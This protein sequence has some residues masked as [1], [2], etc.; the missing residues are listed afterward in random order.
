M[1]HPTH[2]KEFFIAL[3]VLALV[4]SLVSFAAYRFLTKTTVES[5]TDH[6]P[7]QTTTPDQQSRGETTIT[8]MHT[9]VVS[10]VV[11][12]P[13]VLYMWFGYAGLAAAVLCSLYFRI[14]HSQ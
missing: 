10:R 7:V 9:E 12:M 14:R 11:P 5:S 3:A 2:T 8:L 13:V 6:P 1:P 4:H